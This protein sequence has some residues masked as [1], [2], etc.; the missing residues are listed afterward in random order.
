MKAV[1]HLDT[2]STWP[3][4]GWDRF[5]SECKK[6][7]VEHVS[8]TGTNA[9][10][11]LFQHHV[12]L[13]N[14][15]CHRVPGAMVGIRTAGIP[16]LPTVHLY[17]LVTL[18]FCSFDREIHAAMMG[19]ADATDVQ[20]F[21]DELEPERLKV[22]IPLGRKN[23]GDDLERTLVTLAAMGIR[24]V[25]LRELYGQPHV[26]DPLSDREHFEPCGEIYGCPRYAIEGLTRPMVVTYWDVHYVRVG[27]INLFANGHVSKEYAVT[28]GVD[29]DRGTVI[30]QPKESPCTT[31]TP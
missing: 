7:G 12:N 9:E 24:R 20:L 15:V 22:D 1:S 19:R 10:P 16:F 6:S 2:L 28:K 23:A 25:N 17:D 31:S 13:I 26:S 21:V 5:I 18:T 3:L 4:P 14:D 8:V 27:S 11:I 30:P 29:F